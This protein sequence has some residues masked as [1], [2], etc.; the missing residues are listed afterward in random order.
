MS[1]SDPTIPRPPLVPRIGSTEP[2]AALPDTMPPD[3][4]DRLLTFLARFEGKLDQ[5]GKTVDSMFLIV[6]EDRR[7]RIEL[8]DRV[9]AL[10]GM[11]PG[12]PT[13]GHG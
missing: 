1:D 7:D 8:R 13:N 3:A 9:E 2:T 6:Q 11:R 10:E 4:E 12:V 5:M